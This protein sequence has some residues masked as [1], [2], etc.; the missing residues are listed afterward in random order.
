MSYHYRILHIA[1][2]HFS[3]CHFVGKPADVGVQHAKEL[4]Q[5]LRDCE[6][7]PSFDS[8]VLSGDFTFACR[9]DGFDAAVEFINELRRHVKTKSILVIPGNHDVVL[10]TTVQIGRLSLP[11]SKY[12][13]EKEFRTFL[14]RL[15]FPA[16]QINHHLSMV[17]R[18]GGRGAGGLVLVGLNSCRVERRDA[19]GWGYVGADQTY[20]VGQALLSARQGAR[21]E[22]GDLLLAVM[23]HNPLPIWDLGVQS[24]S[25]V[26]DKRKFS[27]VMDAGKTLGFLADLGIGVLL[28]GHTHV[29]SAKRVEGYGTAGLWGANDSDATLILGAG[30]LGIAIGGP[31]DPPH[32]FQIIEID[33]TLLRCHDVTCPSYHPRGT[34]RTWMCKPSPGRAYCIFWDP[35]RTERA[36]KEREHSS[37]VASFDYEVMQSWS[38]LTTK[39]LR[40]EGRNELA[41]LY[42]RV[43]KMAPSATLDQVSRLIESLFGDPPAEY[44]MCEWTLEQH[45]VHLL[46]AG[47]HG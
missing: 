16:E 30:S 26:P 29:Q 33:D 5:I 10:G 6:L 41:A 7:K 15:G 20:E 3:N 4:V 8:I 9:P 12:E 22:E 39:M 46:E 24:V 44:V 19:Q 27:F 37:R 14:S 38:V 43:S 32:H 47:N 31:D 42:E 17:T 13:A 25:S 2:P 28:H 18:I 36:L 45:L 23:H 34:Q 40:P 11:T 35:R 1:D 21:A